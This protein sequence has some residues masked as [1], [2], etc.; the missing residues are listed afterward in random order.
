M[1]LDA[2]RLGDEHEWVVAEL[3]EQEPVSNL[4]LLGF[5]EAHPISRSC[6][7]G[8][9]DP[10]RAVA[11]VLPGR[12]AVPYAPDPEDA[13][14]LGLHLRRQH[15]PSLLVGP[16]VTC[17]ALWRR[18]APGAS[19][20]RYYDQR[21]YVLDTAPPGPDPAGFRRATVDDVRLIV[22]QAAAMEFEDLGVDPQRENPLGHASAVLDRLQGG[23]T[24]VI[25]EREAIV[26]QINVGTLHRLGCQVGGT[27][28][29]PERRGEGL[30]TGGLA[31]TGRRLLV[32]HPRVTLHVNEANEPAVRV[33]EKVGFRRDAALRLV[34]P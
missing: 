34:V 4:F 31:A 1:V 30:A 25:A 26:F 12:L 32:H 10:L 13:A 23:R 21:L 24:W 7:Y 16:R 5:L 29:P 27:Y 17:D 6:W 19:P 18:W 15:N 33:Y 3:L 11:L 2:V 14:R 9:G 8:I 22:P 20:R 28:V